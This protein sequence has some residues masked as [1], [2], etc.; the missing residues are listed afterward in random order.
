M[1]APLDPRPPA[2]SPDQ[3]ERLIGQV[4]KQQPV[5]RAPRSL[6]ARVLEEIERR[7]ALAVAR[8]WWRSSFLHWPMLARVLFVL[9]SLGIVKLALTGVVG[10]TTGIRSPV[11]EPVVDTISKPFSWAETGVNLFSKL[12]NFAGVILD[13]IPSPWLYIGIG[14]AVALYLLVLALGATAYRALYVNK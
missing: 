14:V 12:V 4:L 8:P 11:V 1:A 10:V 7:E 6:Q 9:V 13:A 5:R 3:I 2:R